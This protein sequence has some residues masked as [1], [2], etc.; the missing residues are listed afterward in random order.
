LISSAAIHLDLEDVFLQLMI[1]N[2]SIV[3]VPASQHAAECIY[4]TE[5]RR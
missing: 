2:L 3:S 5:R 4:S 1:Y